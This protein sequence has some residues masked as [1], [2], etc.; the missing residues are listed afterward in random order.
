MGPVLGLNA[1]RAGNFSWAAVLVTGAD[2]GLGEH[3]KSGWGYVG[4]EGDW[5]Q[6]SLAK[7][8]PQERVFVDNHRLLPDMEMD[9]LQITDPERRAAVERMEGRLRRFGYS[10]FAPFITA[11]CVSFP[12]GAAFVGIAADCL[13]R[14][15]RSTAPD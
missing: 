9:A 6:T 12:P 3:S 13:L 8:K 4:E 1:S 7:P 14:L 10:F 11:W 5:K 15:A 2:V